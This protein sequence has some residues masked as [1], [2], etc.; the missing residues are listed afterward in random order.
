MAMAT[1]AATATAVITMV[2]AI[3]PGTG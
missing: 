3:A 2:R 1:I